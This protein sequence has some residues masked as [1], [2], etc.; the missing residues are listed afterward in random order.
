MPSGG[1]RMASSHKRDS[2]MEPNSGANS[3]ASRPP[4]TI[5]CALCGRQS[6]VSSREA[7][8]WRRAKTPART[9]PEEPDVAYEVRSVLGIAYSHGATRCPGQFSCNLG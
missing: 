6:F 8:S 4:I 7:Q 2:S 1:F 3:P 5:L 9:S